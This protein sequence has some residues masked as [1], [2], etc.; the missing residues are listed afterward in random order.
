MSLP[1]AELETETDLLLRT[2]LCAVR[3]KSE[4]V[5]STEVLESMHKKTA[6]DA[7]LNPTTLVISLI[8]L[9]DNITV[10]GLGFFLPTVHCSAT[11]E[12]RQLLTLVT[13]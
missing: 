3:V 6:I 5:G 12:L 7:M 11:V 9:L 2:A 1:P 13:P 8:F 4:N 10:Q